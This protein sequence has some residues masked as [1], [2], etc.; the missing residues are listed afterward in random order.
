M[1]MSRV[2]PES[3][4]SMHVIW[5]IVIR[6]GAFPSSQ[7]LPGIMVEIRVPGPLIFARQSSRIENQS[8]ES[9]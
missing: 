9:I 3:R 6:S 4:T 8:S 1:K 2:E 7:E 5:N